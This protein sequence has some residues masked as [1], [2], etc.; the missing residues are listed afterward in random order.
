MAM[1]LLNKPTRWRLIQSQ[2]DSG[3]WNMAVDETI[4]EASTRGDVLP[5]L[6]LYAWDPACLSLGHAQPVTDVDEARLQANGWDLVRRPTGGRAILHTDELTYSVTGPQD[7]PILAGEI[8]SSYRRL[9]SAILAAV[10]QIGVGVQAL[11]QDKT[12]N[13]TP[14]PVC[15]EIPSSYEITYNNKKLVGSAQA[16]RKGGVLQHGTLPLVGDL[17][18]ITQ[19]LAFPDETSRTLAAER[20]LKRATTVQSALG[21]TISWQQAAEAFIQAFSEV[22]NLDL[23]PGQLTEDEISRAGQLLQEKYANPEWTRRL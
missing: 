1:E 15:F 21:K 23:V 11:P 16:R 12:N 20:L 7:E 10:E 18:R 19:V 3:P 5:T 6:R 2:A 14:E 22:L 17:A 4:F 8:M 9:S 13:A